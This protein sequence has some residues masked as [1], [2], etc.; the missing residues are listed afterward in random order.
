MQ[1]LC[2]KVLGPLEVVRDGVPITPSAPKLQRVFSLLAV[3]ANHIVRTEQ[4]IEELWEENPPTSVKTTLQTYVYQLRKL[5]ELDPAQ[6]P[7]ARVRRDDGQP[8][9]LTLSGGYM[10]AVDRDALDSSHFERQATQGW[11][12]LD[13]GDAEAAFHTLDGALRLWRG[14]ALVDLNPGPVLQA[15]VLRLDEMRKNALEHRIDAALQLGRHQEVL[16]ELT[17]LAAQQPTHEGFQAKLMLALYRSGRRSEALGVY[18]RTRSALADELGL[19]PGAE[20]QRVHRAV[21]A[22]N[23]SL[24]AVPAQVRRQPARPEPPRQLP[25]AGPGLVGRDSELH[26]VVT[27][28]TAPDRRGP[29]VVTVDGPPGSGKTA[30]CVHAGHDVREKFPDGQFHASL[31]DAAGQPVDPGTVLAGFLRA[32]GVPGDRIAG[33]VAERSTQFRTWTADRRVL[34]VLD[35]VLDDHQLAPLL[36]AGRGCA[37][38]V[39]SRMQLSDPSVTTVVSLSPLSGAD[40]VRVLSGLV[41]PERLAQDPDGTRALVGR[42]DGLPLALHAAATR[43]RHRPHWPVRRA[44]DWAATGAD[45]PFD[46]RS[47][48]SLS[49]RVATPEVRWAFRTLSTSDAGS[50]SLAAASAVLNLDGCLAETLL[51]DLVN[52]HLLEFEHAADH[53]EEHHYRMLPTFRDIGRRLHLEAELLGAARTEPQP[54]LAVTTGDAYQPLCHEAGRV[55]VAPNRG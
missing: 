31:A 43:L 6:R 55:A 20:L 9:L 47:S 10:L 49:Y 50:L 23:G 30:L 45:D 26:T 27:A 8:V 22:A 1:M 15:E 13:T 16:G 44:A 36:P 12:E 32:I 17:R 54:A 24:D 14:S 4:L 37:V 35:D 21:L 28:V 5:L 34:V 18:Q 48:V 38:V 39:A 33:S 2:V 42:C 25:P 52:L 51:D 53:T 40:G 11:T 7:S 19:D 3:S 29:A 41:G 46:L